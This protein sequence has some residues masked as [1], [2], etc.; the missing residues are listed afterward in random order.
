MRTSETSARA[1]AV[2]ARST[3]MAIVRMTRLCIAVSWRLE[4]KDS[5]DGVVGGIGLLIGVIRRAHQRADR[6]VAEAQRIRFAF[7]HREG[8]RVHVAQHRQVA[9]G[10]LKILA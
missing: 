4:N 8:V 5:A 1:L 3:T 10:R 9:G 7:E 2:Q 6:S